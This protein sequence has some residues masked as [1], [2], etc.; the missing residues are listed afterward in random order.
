MAFIDFRKAYDC[1]SRNLLWKKLLETDIMGRMFDATVSL[2]T[3]VKSR[4][5]LNGLCYIVLL[6]L[7]LTVDLNKD[8]CYL[9][10]YLTYS[11]TTCSLQLPNLGVDIVLDDTLA[12]A[13]DIIILIE[14]EDGLKIMLDSLNTRCC[15]YTMTINGEKSKVV[16]F[17]NPSI[18]KTSSN[19]I[20]W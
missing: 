12:Y 9:L 1:I 8:V 10:Y 6:G 17:G 11:L 2:Y 13:D 15:K 5:R 16:D 4:V 20:L 7:M 19:F 3:N 14:S 18:V